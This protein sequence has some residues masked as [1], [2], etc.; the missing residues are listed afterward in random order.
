M[1][2]LMQATFQSQS[3]VT[4]EEKKCYTN[5][6]IEG[7]VKTLCSCSFFFF[8]F[9]NFPDLTFLDNLRFRH[10]AIGQRFLLFFLLNICQ[11]LVWIM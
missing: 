4:M 11:L 3:T 6:F 7:I 2:S 8:T 5:S 1:S 9:Y 10:V